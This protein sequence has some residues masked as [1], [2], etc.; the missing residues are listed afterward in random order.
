MWSSISM[1]CDC[2]GLCIADCVVVRC[3]AWYVRPGTDARH[4]VAMYVLYVWVKKLL[5]AQKL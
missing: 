4:V 5:S 1:R 2:V 3:V